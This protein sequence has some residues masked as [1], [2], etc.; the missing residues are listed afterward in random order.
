MFQGAVKGSPTA[1]YITLTK[2]E[3]TETTY[4]QIN[5]LHVMVPAT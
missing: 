3:K 2:K 4:R 1:I 5:T